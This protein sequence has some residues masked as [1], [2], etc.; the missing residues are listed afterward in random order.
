MSEYNSSVNNSPTPTDY[1]PMDMDL[2]LESMAKSLGRDAMPADY[3][4]AFDKLAEKY[5]EDAVE[6]SFTENA[7]N[8]FSDDLI[9]EIETSDLPPAMKEAVTDA[10]QADKVKTG[11]NAGSDVAEAVDNELGGFVDDLSQLVMK[12]LIKALQEE[13]KELMAP[14]SSGGKGSNGGE[15]KGGAGSAGT[16]GKSAAG[17]AEGAGAGGA[18]GAEGAG[19]GAG[20]APGAGG[21]E[22]AGAGSAPGA[23]GAEGAD[24]GGAPGAEGAGA[25][26]APG[27]EGAGDAKGT[28][29]TEAAGATDSAD[30]TDATAAGGGSGGG[31]NWL[32]A[33]AKAMGKV[34]GKF[35]EKQV[36]AGKKLGAMEGSEGSEGVFAELNAEMQAAAQMFKI[37]QEALATVVKTAGEGMVS[38]ARK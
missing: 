6:K 8:Q 5:G 2:G 4:N 12:D 20:G 18:P 23:G 3:Q 13:T 30:G 35:L 9:A 28:G 36:E 1:Q 11:G 16:K 26:G 21:A 17:G 37:A 22:G 32:I 34:S 38:V 14:G 33:L 31:E 27:A 19:A 29:E 15:G 7:I 25:G 10:L 24:A